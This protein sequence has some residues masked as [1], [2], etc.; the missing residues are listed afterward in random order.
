MRSASR[1]AVRV[2]VFDRGGDPGHVGRAARAVRGRGLGQTEDARHRLDA[3]HA[4]GALRRERAVAEREVD[5][6]GGVAIEL[7]IDREPRALCVARAEPREL[8]RHVAQPQGGG[9]GPRAPP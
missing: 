6:R 3:V 4:R 1:E 8:L 5:A 7:A 9:R 2:L